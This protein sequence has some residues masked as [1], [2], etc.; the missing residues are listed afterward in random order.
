MTEDERIIREMAREKQEH[1]DKIRSIRE[2]RERERQYLI[3]GYTPDERQ[4][5]RDDAEIW[6]EERE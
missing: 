1:R 6:G 4:E 3:L 2:A 5:F